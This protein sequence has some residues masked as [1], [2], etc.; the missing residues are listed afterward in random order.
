MGFMCSSVVSL[1]LVCI[2]QKKSLKDHLSLVMRKPAFCICENK[3]ADLPLLHSPVCVRPGQK[4]RRPV[5]SQRGSFVFFALEKRSLFHKPSL[6]YMYIYSQNV[7]T[8]L[9]ISDHLLSC[10]PSWIKAITSRDKDSL[11]V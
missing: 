1:N 7:G 11:S 10:L 2:L 9:H 4:P 5:F 6:K 3:D 8:N